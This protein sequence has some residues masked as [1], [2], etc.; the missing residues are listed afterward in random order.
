MKSRFGHQILTLKKIATASVLVDVVEVETVDLTKLSFK[1]AMKQL[2]EII[3]KMD[4][5]EVKLEDV[6]TLYEKGMALK[7]VCEE[8]LQN[9]KLKVEKITLSPNG[10]IHTEPFETE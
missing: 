5:A 9:A 10:T 1:D 2:E 7:K 3:Q 4:S 8:K 6:V